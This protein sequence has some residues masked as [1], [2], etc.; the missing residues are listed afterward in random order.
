MKYNNMIN[1]S[2]CNPFIVT[3]SIPDEL[4]HADEG[5]NFFWCKETPEAVADTMKSALEWLCDM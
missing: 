3:R 2:F 5:N 1:N 4:M